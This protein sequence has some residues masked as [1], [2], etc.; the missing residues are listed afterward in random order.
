M[1]DVPPGSVPDLSLMDLG[2]GDVDVEILTGKLC[3]EVGCENHLPGSGQDNYHYARKYCDVH[4]VGSKKGKGK[5]DRKPGGIPSV[6][7]N[8]NQGT[9][10]RNAADKRRAKVA[11][12]ATQ[13]AQTMGTLILLGGDQVCGQAVIEGAAQW[14]AAIGD[15]S[16]YQPVL[17]KIFAPGGEITGQGFAWVAALAATAGIVIPVLAHHGMISDDLALKFVAGTGAVTGVAGAVDV[18]AADNA[19]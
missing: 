16:V 6:N 11:A 10:G 9:Q 3:A 5:R 15:L 12:G 2:V 8:L 14:G 17:E 1:T 19:A 18:T 4:F 7:V 13:M